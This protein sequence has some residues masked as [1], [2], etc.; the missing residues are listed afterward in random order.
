MKI[1]N[2]LKFNTFSQ[3]L[4]T[5]SYKLKAISGFTLIEMIVSIALF[6]FVMLGVTAVL[7]NIIAA[8]HK[9]EGQKV[10]IDNLSLT[11]ESM[12]RNLRTG[13]NYAPDPAGSSCFS[14]GTTYIDFT[15]QDG[16]SAAY[17]RSDANG[18]PSSGGQYIYKLDNGIGAI[19][20]APEITINNLCFYI[21]GAGSGQQPNVLVTIDG[22]TSANTA[23]GAKQA[24]K[25]EFNIET[26]V[27][28]RQLNIH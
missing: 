28:Q 20:T 23:A 12:A 13:Y 19:M 14:T 27:S 9:A 24:T 10:T 6:S 11:I 21:G 18:N 22:Y 5:K 26:F 3:K 25:S 2:R 15:D 16:K 4:K 8:D 17:Y 1:K 7:M